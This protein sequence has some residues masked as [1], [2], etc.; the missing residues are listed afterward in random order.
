VHNPG[1][2]KVPAARNFVG[3]ATSPLVRT[4]SIS[5]VPSALSNKIPGRRRNR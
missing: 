5:N 4:F 1:V 3:H 2:I